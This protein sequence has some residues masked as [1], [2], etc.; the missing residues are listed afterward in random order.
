[1]RPTGL[2]GSVVFDA[3]GC[4]CIF[5][6]SA[7]A[8]NSASATVTSLKILALWLQHLLSVDNNP[9]HALLSCSEVLQCRQ[10]LLSTLAAGTTLVVDRYAFSGVAFTAAKGIPTLDLAWCKVGSVTLRKLL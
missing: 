1:M 8:Q 3:A 4:S 2:S 9:L 6:L 5:C 10:R 7:C